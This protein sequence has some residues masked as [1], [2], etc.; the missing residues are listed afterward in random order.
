MF[1]TYTHKLSLYPKLV[2]LCSH[3]NVVFFSM[4]ANG[5]QLKEVRNLLAQ[6]CLSR[7]TLLNVLDYM[8]NAKMLRG[9]RL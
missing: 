1:L 4:T 5:L 8:A 2:I 6:N 3:C 9:A 7:K